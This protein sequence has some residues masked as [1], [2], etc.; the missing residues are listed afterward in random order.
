MGDSIYIEDTPDKICIVDVTYPDN[1]SQIF[2]GLNLT[3]N[4]TIEITMDKITS[5]MRQDSD[6]L[7]SGKKKQKKQI[8]IFFVFL[9]VCFGVI[10]FK[11]YFCFF[12]NLR[13]LSKIID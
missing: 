9:W 3:T 1:N 5:W 10:F 11:K 6:C 13:E 12:V 2:I 4:S 8:G 7:K